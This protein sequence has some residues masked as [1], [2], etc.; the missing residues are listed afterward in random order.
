MGTGT[1]WPR[2]SLLCTDLAYIHESSVQCCLSPAALEDGLR[3]VGSKSQVNVPAMAICDLNA[4]HMLARVTLRRDRKGVREASITQEP[5]ERFDV[6]P[7][8]VVV[9]HRFAICERP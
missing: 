6:P 4:V 7:H 5:A 8:C 2:T 9:P 1:S 3:D